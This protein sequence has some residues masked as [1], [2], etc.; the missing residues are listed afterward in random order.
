MN[1]MPRSKTQLA[2]TLI[3]L[4]V[5]IAII[6]IL[7]GIIIVTMSNS[8]ESAR[9]AK[10][11]VFSNSVRSSLGA[12]LVAEWN[13]DSIIGSSAPYTT[14]DYWGNNTAT[15]GDGSTSS[16]F[17]TIQSGSSCVSG[18]CFQFNG[19]GQYLVAN[20]SNLAITGNSFTLSVWAKPVAFGNY[21]AVMG[22]CGFHMT[23][24]FNSSKNF[25]VTI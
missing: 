15:L 13:T 11:K 8:T 1:F 20:T 14:L 23:L 2:F 16:T 19:S 3:E 6:G 18:Q 12:N 24:G 7:S 4:L 17:P 22:K 25:L 10:L 5:V 9:I 21:V